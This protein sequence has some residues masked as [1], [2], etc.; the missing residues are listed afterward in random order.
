MSV[1]AAAVTKLNGVVIVGDSEISDDWNKD[2]DGY[3]KIW[4]SKDE[5]YIFGGAGS[6]RDIQILQ[7]LTGWPQFYPK[8]DVELFGVRDV[9]PSMKEALSNNGRLISGKNSTDHFN[10]EM[11]M[12][13]DNNLMVVDDDFGIFVPASRRMAIGSGKSEALGYLGNKG[14]W[15][16]ADVIEAARRATLTAVGVGGPLWVVSTKSMEVEKLS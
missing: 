6:A 9:V 3:Q 14:P 7:Y 10:A 11:I 8:M 5:G 13:W 16:K 1:I 4:V 12:A 15:T 2:T